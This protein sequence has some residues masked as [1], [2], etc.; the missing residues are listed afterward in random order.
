MTRSVWRGKRDEH[1]HN[2]MFQRPAE[3]GVWDENGQRGSIDTNSSVSI[4][5]W[6]L[7][8]S[9]EEGSLSKNRYFWHLIYKFNHFQVLWRDDEHYPLEWNDGG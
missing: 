9:R 5:G 8:L 7:G 3:P 2:H 4:Q 6:I 1:Y